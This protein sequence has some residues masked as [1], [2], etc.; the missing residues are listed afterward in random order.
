MNNDRLNEIEKNIIHLEERYQELG[1]C[2]EIVCKFL[3]EIH[4]E[5]MILKE[6]NES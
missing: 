5:V 2:I 3:R 1:D 6:E 4:K